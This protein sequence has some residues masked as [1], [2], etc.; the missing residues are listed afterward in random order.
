[1]PGETERDS[2]Q[3]PPIRQLRKRRALLRSDEGSREVRVGPAERLR[4]VHDA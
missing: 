3:R 4:H 2:V 1:M